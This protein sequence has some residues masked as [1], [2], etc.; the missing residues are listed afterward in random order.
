MELASIG[1]PSGI[2]FKTN[3]I[4]DY[5]VIEKISQASQA[6]VPITIMAR[7]ISC[8]VPGIS[9]FTENVRVVS[10]V[11]R[12][13]EHSRIYGFGPQEN[14]AIYLSSADL[15]TRNLDKRIEVAW[16]VTNDELRKR[17]IDYISVS[18]S[19]TAKLRELKPD[20]SYT[21]LGAQAACGEAKKGALFDSQEYL[22]ERALQQS[23]QAAQNTIDKEAPKKKL[24]LLRKP[25]LEKMKQALPKIPSKSTS[26]TT[27]PASSKEKA[28][29]LLGSIR[30]RFSK[31]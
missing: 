11:G 22:I 28:K 23:Q 12:L 30:K 3:A 13:L 27:K 18:L 16:P 19:D 29:R 31:K 15:M 1:K 14:M 10:I 25:S 9:G 21:A 26:K 4:T 20:G 7:G 17:I 5:D 8:I 24:L 6:G 2:F